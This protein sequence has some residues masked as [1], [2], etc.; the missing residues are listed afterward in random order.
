[1]GGSDGWQLVAVAVAT[2]T[3]LL[4]LWGWGADGT[5][6][7]AAPGTES[8]GAVTSS[9]GKSP[10]EALSGRG[11]ALLCRR[12]PLPLGLDREGQESRPCWV[13]AVAVQWLPGASLWQHVWPGI[14]ERLLSHGSRGTSCECEQG[15]AVRAA[16]TAPWERAETCTRV[17]R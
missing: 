16:S 3:P 5:P 8:P 13:P 9:G 15:Q 17:T 2:P 14:G 1:M 4:S 7:P 10:G 12:T 6:G 11:Q